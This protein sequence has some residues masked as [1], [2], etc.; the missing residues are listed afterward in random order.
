MAHKALV[1]GTAFDISGGKTMVGGTNYSINNGRT[2]IG[3]TGYD[4]AFNPQWEKWNLGSKS[5]GEYTKTSQATDKIYDASSVKIHTSSSF[6]TFKTTPSGT[7]WS[8]FSEYYTVTS[9]NREND[10]VTI[11]KKNYF[12][13]EPLDGDGV[14]RFNTW[15]YPSRALLYYNT[16]ATTVYYYYSV[17]ICY[18][19]INGFSNV[20]T[21]SKGKETIKGNT[22]LE[23]VSAPDGTYPTNG[24]SGDYWYVLIS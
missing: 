13:I 6:P 12:I 15:T 8:G 11:P 14:K 20:Y 9:D 18:F 4:I 24:Q 17:S 16:A 19:A 2:L 10:K 21:P 7:V 3:G 22:L 1:G 23:I 5:V